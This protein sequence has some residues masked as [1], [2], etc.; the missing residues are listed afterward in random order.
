MVCLQKEKIREHSKRIKERG[1]NKMT[2]EQMIDHLINIFGLEDSRVIWFCGLCEQYPSNKWNDG[3][4][5][6]IYHCLF[7]LVQYESELQQ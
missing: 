3:C 7:D 2:R 5:T 4:L 6:G 1:K